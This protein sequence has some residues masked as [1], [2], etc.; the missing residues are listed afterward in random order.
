MNAEAKVRIGFPWWLRPFLMKN[1]LAI[2]LGRRIYF[3]VGV[4]ES[5]MTRLLRHELAH[6]R[7]IERHGL[8]RFY[9][10]YVVEFVRH[11]RRVRS[12]GRAYS[13]IS[14]EIEANAAEEDL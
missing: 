7:Q 14:F 12:V 13:L 1:V 8:L 3:R 2:T 6:V 4:A 5:Y 10:L 11:L 9:V